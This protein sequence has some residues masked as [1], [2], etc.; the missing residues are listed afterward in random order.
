MSEKARQILPMLAE[1]ALVYQT[2]QTPE[3]LAALAEIYA[4]D[5]EGES[6]EAINAAF[7]LHRKRSTRFPTPAHIM[8]ILPECRSLPVYEA[9]PAASKTPG[10]GRL[11]F[12]A[13][14]GDQKAQEALD[15][16]VRT[17]ARVSAV[18]SPLQHCQTA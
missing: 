11:A 5:L 4:E 16:L 18:Q 12:A 3:E 10:M 6:L 15:R 7:S 17:T 14:K 9:L 13:F 8:A 2:T 1:A